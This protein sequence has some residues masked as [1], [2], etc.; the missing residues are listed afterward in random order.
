MGDADGKSGYRDGRAKGSL[1][2][3]PPAK[4]FLRLRFPLARHR[5]AFL[6]SRFAPEVST[7]VVVLPV[8]YLASTTRISSPDF[9]SRR[10]DCSRREPVAQVFH[11][12][13]FTSDVS[14]HS[15]LALSGETVSSRAS[16]IHV[17]SHFFAGND[18]RLL[19]DSCQCGLSLF[20][21]ISKRS[22]LY[23]TFALFIKGI[24][25]GILNCFFLKFD[26]NSPTLIFY[27]VYIIL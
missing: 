16:T 7:L 22:L 17:N 14:P 21:R 1:A 25:K 24:I 20:L 9:V 5:P 23:A 4:A 3:V 8:L 10:L 26:F 19:K 6:S 18:G 11:S 13:A 15:S 12:R 2:G 27:T